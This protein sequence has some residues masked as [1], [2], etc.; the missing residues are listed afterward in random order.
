MEIEKVQFT[1]EKETLL[2]TLYARALESQSKDPTLRDP[3]A[4]AA[5]RRIGHDFAKF[6]MSSTDILG[7]VSRAKLFDLWTVEYLA[8]N[9]NATVLHLGCGLD[10]RVFRIDP[11]ASVS[12]FDVDYPEV[13]ELRKRLFPVRASYRMIG[14][15]VTAPGWLD[16]IPADRPALIIAEGLLMYLSAEAAPALLERLVNHFPGGQLIFDAVSR[17]GIRMQKSNKAVKASGA[18]LGWGLDDPHELEHRIPRLKLI[19]EMTAVDPNLPGIHKAST[20][21]RVT[22]GILK[23]IPAQGGWR[24]SCVISFR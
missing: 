6:K 4:E 11:S 3:A 17:M 16:E 18:T 12:W 21:T 13:I 22:L 24:S 10:S 20:G 2:A 19:T 8:N 14:S 1:K 15:S 23:L 7:I 9:L 5:L